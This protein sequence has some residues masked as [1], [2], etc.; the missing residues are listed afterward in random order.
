[1]SFYSDLRFGIDAERLLIMNYPFLEHAPDRSHDL[2]IKLTN[3]RVEL[4]SDSYDMHKYGN[5]IIERWSKE[6]KVGGPWQA[7]KHG[8]RYYVYNFAQ[9]EKVFV[10]NVVQLL[11]RMK[12]IIKKHEL[13]LH[14][15]W[16]PGYITQ[17]YKVPI[18]MLEDLDLGME[19]IQSDYLTAKKKHDKLNK[20]LTK[21]KK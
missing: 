17:Y 13:K 1:M 8:C 11:A 19:R 10:F 9:N 5:I 21:Q 14:D 12:K 2:V 3:I 18:T 7:S 4:K 20:A 16:N 6:D 15:K